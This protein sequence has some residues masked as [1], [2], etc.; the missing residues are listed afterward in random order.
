MLFKK[1]LG[2]LLKLQSSY[3]RYSGGGMLKYC[4][5]YECFIKCSCHSKNPHFV[6]KISSIQVE[7]A[8]CGIR[9]IKQ[10]EQMALFK[11][12]HKLN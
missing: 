9:R 8:A 3:S 10:L 6:C 1:K 2:K 5:V 7:T 12:Q 11:L 4:K